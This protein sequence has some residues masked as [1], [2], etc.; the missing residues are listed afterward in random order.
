[1]QVVGYL[2]SITD[3]ID[4][5]LVTVS[6]Y[7]VANS[8]VLVPQR[9]DPGRRSRELSDAQV[10]ARQAGTLYKGSEEFRAVIADLPQARHEVLVRLADWADTLERAGLVK[11]ATYRGKDSITTLLPRLAA[12]NAGLVTIYCD[13]GSAS[14]AFFRSVFERR[15]PRSLSAVEAALGARVKQGNATHEFTDTLLTA[16][17]RAYEEAVGR[18]RGSEPS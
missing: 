7:T 15:A 6:A 9:I 13:H 4:I 1:V 5:D 10:T 17:T 14:L 16:L 2:Q 18:H 12:D 3:K 11:L 8:Q